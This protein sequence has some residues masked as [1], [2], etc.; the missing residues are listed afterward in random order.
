MFQ[1][2]MIDW[3]FPIVNCFH[4]F[5]HGCITPLTEFG[6]MVRWFY[7][8]VWQLGVTP[9][10]LGLSHAT[11][12]ALEHKTYNKAQFEVSKSTQARVGQIMLA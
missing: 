11:A 1:S 10:L 8:P 3:H 12:M 2:S 6:Q 4:C 7:L 5:L 9:E